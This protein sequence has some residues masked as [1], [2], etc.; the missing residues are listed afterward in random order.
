MIQRTVF[1]FYDFVVV[2]RCYSFR[3]PRRVLNIRASISS[4][5]QNLYLILTTGQSSLL[6]FCDLSAV[7]RKLEWISIIKISLGRNNERLSRLFD[8]TL[9]RN[10]KKSTIGIQ[11]FHHQVSLSPGR[12]AVVETIRIQE[13]T[14]PRSAVNKVSMSCLQG[15]PI[16]L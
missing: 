10:S 4:S 14:R 16:I 3:R 5:K 6:L 2:P 9:S 11:A 8:D 12:N 7:I 15:E 1:A 13:E